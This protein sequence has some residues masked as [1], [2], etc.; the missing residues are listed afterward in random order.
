MNEPL[1]SKVLSPIR[2]LNN[3]TR[4]QQ[5]HRV[6]RG[7]HCIEMHTDVKVRHTTAPSSGGTEMVAQVIKIIKIIT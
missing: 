7:H 5:Y 6:I 1:A 4:M 3:L 2:D